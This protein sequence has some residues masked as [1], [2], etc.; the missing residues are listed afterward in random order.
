MY[1]TSAGEITDISDPEWLGQF[2][3]AVSSLQSMQYSAAATNYSQ[4]T[5]GYADNQ[6]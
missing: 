4:Y 1:T 2:S 3:A 6:G 5:E